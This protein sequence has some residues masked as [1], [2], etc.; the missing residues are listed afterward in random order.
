MIGDTVGTIRTFRDISHRKHIEAEREALLDSERRA[1]TG[2]DAA[3]RLK[4][5]FLTNLSHEL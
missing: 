4:D 1:R 3:N 2:A 5:E